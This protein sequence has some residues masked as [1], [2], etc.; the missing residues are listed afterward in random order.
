MGPSRR[1]KKEKEA[2]PQ[3]ALTACAG[4]L[5]GAVARFV[6]GPLD[7]LKIRFQVQL[8]P[9]AAGAQPAHYTSM[10][11]ALATIVREEGVKVR[12][13]AGRN[14]AAALRSQCSATRQPIAPSHGHRAC[15]QGL[16]RG[17]V[18]G[19]LLTVPYTAVQFM[20]LQ[21]CRQVARQFGLQDSPRWQAAVPFVSGAVAGAAAT[22]ASYPFDLLRT[23]LAAQG[24]PPVYATMT[25]AGAVGRATQAEA[26]CRA[27][28]L[29][30]GLCVALSR[31]E[32]H[33]QRS[34]SAQ[35]F[36]RRLSSIEQ[37][38]LVWLPR[39]RS[40]R[41]CAAERRARAVP[42]PGRDGAGDHAVRGAT[43]WPLRRLQ[44][45]LRPCPGAPP[46]AAWPPL[47]VPPQAG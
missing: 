23:T 31:N 37:V 14:T 46:G 20:A 30:L 2:A 3:P 15:V 18:P 6:V 33:V 5:A 36:A 7:V 26:G 17:T 19:Q 28:G 39:C 40:A 45:S 47:L 43:V 24:E 29:L 34:A 35:L 12:G 9:I 4:A 8:E 16:W 22:V 25:E 10:R 27:T 32:H 11:Q 1:R 38:S 44:Q 42:W 13:R 41:H 21:Q